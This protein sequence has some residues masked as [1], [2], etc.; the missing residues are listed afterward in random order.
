M[1]DVLI[2]LAPLAALCSVLPDTRHYGLHVV[3]PVPG[4][5]VHAG[6]A[7]DHPSGCGGRRIRR[8]QRHR[9]EPLRTGDALD[10]AQ[11][12]G[13]AARRGTGRDSRV[14]RAARHVRRSVHRVLVP[15]HHAVRHGA[16]RDPLDGLALTAVVALVLCGGTVLAAARSAGTRRPAS[17][18]QAARALVGLAGLRMHELRV[19]PVD[20]ACPGRHW[21]SGIDLAAARGT[22]VMATLPGVATVDPVGDRVWTARDH[23][24]RWRSRAASTDTSTPSRSRAATYVDGRRGHRHCR[25]NRQRHAART[26]TSRSAATASP[27]IRVWTSRCREEGSDRV[28]AGRAARITGACRARRPRAPACAR[29]GRRRACAPAATRPRCAARA[30]TLVSTARIQSAQM[31]SGAMTRP[32][33]VITTRSGRASNPPSTVKPSDCARARTYETSK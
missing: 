13:N 25:C 33:T 15:V 20:L 24:P 14:I 18:S 30:V 22:P 21:H 32:I 6:R 7:A 29:V 2:V 16:R 11:G 10:P 27:R 17:P 23:R 8:R 28:R 26:C 12:A 5:R 19:E 4:R 9:G 1:L 31:S 3:A